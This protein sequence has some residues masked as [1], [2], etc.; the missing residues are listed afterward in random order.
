MKISPK[1]VTIFVDDFAH[2]FSPKLVK[3]LLNQWNFQKLCHQNLWQFKWFAQVFKNIFTKIGE[4]YSQKNVTN[5]GKVYSQ[6]LIKIKWL[7]KF[8][9]KKITEICEYLFTSKFHHN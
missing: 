2:I 6:N 1:S 9:W 7:A 3:V 5:F 8:W 4:N